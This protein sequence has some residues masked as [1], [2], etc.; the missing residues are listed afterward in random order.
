VIVIITVDATDMRDCR[1]LAISEL[2]DTNGL[3]IARIQQQRIPIAS[4]VPR[5]DLSNLSSATC[6]AMLQT[7]DLR[8]R[9]YFARFRWFDFMWSW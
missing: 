7:T 1:N 2:F 3:K 8:Y 4:T 6:I 9:E 5:D